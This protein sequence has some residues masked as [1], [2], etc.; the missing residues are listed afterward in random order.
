MLNYFFVHIEECI[1]HV[2]IVF[3]DKGKKSSEKEETHILAR[4][5]ASREPKP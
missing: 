1:L 4:E 2:C 5:N 3:S